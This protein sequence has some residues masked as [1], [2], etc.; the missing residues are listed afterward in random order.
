MPTTPEEKIAQPTD[1]TSEPANS[2][3]KRAIW[4]AFRDDHA[5]HQR[6]NIKPHELEA[7]SR[8]AMLGSLRSKADLIFMLSAIRRPSRR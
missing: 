1:K 4:K 7:L 5:L 6:H 2:S 8:I 3:V